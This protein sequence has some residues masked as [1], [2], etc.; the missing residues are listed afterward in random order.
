MKRKQKRVVGDIVQIELADGSLCFGRVLKSPLMAFYDLNTT[1]AP[2]LE[3]IVN[4][5]VLFKVWL[6][7]YAVTSGHWKI[8]HHAD[9]EEDLQVDVAFYKQDL[10]SK[11]LFIHQGSNELPATYEQCEKL[12][13][14]AVWDPVHIEDR[15]RD[16]YLGLP[17][18]WVE[19]LR[20]KR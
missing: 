9:L 18:K 1:K 16:H 14:A 7:D 4:L 8:I 19:S 10:I 13:C 12:E 20:I 2:P 6:M 15:L 3:E 11:K 17:N 5:P